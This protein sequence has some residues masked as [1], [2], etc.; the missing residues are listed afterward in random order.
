VRKSLLLR[1]KI[2]I[3]SMNASCQLKEDRW[4]SF[5]GT[6]AT[7]L[8]VLLLVVVDANHEPDPLAAGDNA[9]AGKM[10]ICVSGAM[11]I[12]VAS[13]ISGLRCFVQRDFW[14]LAWLVPLG[15][16]LFALVEF[17]EWQTV[18]LERLQ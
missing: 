15:I 4:G 17:S 16:S 3:R 13:V 10:I 9:W 14:P 6:L 18:V 7:V 11:A 8:A 12:F 1:S 2:D 5:R